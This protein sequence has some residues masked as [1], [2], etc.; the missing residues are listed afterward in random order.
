MPIRFH[1]CGGAPEGTSAIVC[2]VVVTS[3][4]VAGELLE[5]APG[6]LLAQLAPEP[7][8]PVAALGVQGLVDEV[9]F[10]KIYRLLD[11]VTH[12]SSPS[13]RDGY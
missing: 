5:N 2:G 13:V 12:L 6:L 10:T 8:A 11:S 4:V 1:L 7:T 9:T 3:V